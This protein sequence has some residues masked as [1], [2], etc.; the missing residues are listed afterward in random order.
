[1]LDCALLATGGSPVCSVPWQLFNPAECMVQTSQ[2]A[3]EPIPLLTSW[4]LLADRQ[5]PHCS[6]LLHGDAQETNEDMPPSGSE[7]SNSRGFKAGFIH[8]RPPPFTSPIPLSLVT[9]WTD[10]CGAE[11]TQ[12]GGISFWTSIPPGTK[13]NR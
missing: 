4:S 12:S 10:Y 7:L 1:M 3:R 5:A 9:G 6:P 2:H 8:F 13:Q 11:P